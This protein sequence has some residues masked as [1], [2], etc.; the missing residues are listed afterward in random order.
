M[1]YVRTVNTSHKKMTIVE[2]MHQL[3]VKVTLGQVLKKQ[4]GAV[5]LR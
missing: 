3:G 2:K 5:S 4:S 1:K